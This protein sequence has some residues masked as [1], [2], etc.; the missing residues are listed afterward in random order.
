MINM[1]PSIHPLHNQT[2]ISNAL[3]MFVVGG[4]ERDK[5]SIIS[6]SHLD[7]EPKPRDPP[8]YLCVCTLQ[9]RSHQV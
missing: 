9:A 6:I 4:G 5:R 2:F 8:C 1:Y 7:I 3:A